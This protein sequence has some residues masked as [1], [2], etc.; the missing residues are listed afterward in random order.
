VRELAPTRAAAVNYVQ[1]LFPSSSWVLRYSARWLLGDFIAGLTI[2]LVVVPQALAYALLAE[3]PPAYGLYTSFTGAALYWLFGT[4]KDIVIG[5]SD[6]SDSD[7][8]V[9]HL[10]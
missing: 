1:S 5:V 9:S 8:L 10:D 6:Y 2:G 4:S 3:L 7:P